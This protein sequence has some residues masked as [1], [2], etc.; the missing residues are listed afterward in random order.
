MNRCAIAYVVRWQGI[1][2]APE[3]VFATIEDTPLGSRALLESGGGMHGYW[4]PAQGYAEMDETDDQILLQY[5]GGRHGEAGIILEPV[6]VERWNELA[7][8]T[9]A[10]KVKSFDEITSILGG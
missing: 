1:V 4:Y 9:G 2:K 7:E 6:N 3:L 8:L 10:R 5:R